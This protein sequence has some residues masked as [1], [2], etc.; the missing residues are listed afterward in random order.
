MSAGETVIQSP[1]AISGSWLGSLETV[2][3]IMSS[4]N[5]ASSIQMCSVLPVAMLDTAA[6]DE[7]AL[8]LRD[9]ATCIFVEGASKLG[10]PR[11]GFI[12]CRVHL[13]IIARNRN[14]V[15]HD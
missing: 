15:I 5:P 1:F 7:S 6:F 14:G 10:Q 2:P 3:T 12:H 8:D 13:G 11:A 9:D 4:S